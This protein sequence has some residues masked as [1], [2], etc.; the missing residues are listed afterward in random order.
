M[1]DIKYLLESQ[2]S[3]LDSHNDKSRGDSVFHNSLHG[4][5]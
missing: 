4:L 5:Q 1:I 2:G 3:G